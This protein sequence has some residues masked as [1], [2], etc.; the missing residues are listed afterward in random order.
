MALRICGYL[1]CGVGIAVATYWIVDKNPCWL[2]AGN[3]LGYAAG[4]VLAMGLK[5]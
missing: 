4:W 5:A 3:L 1:L 2:V